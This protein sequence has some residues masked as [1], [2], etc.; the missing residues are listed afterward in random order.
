[1]RAH[2]AIV[3]AVPLLLCGCLAFEPL[4]ETPPP[5]DSAP[6]ITGTYPPTHQVTLLPT[7]PSV[8]NCDIT[9]SVTALAPQGQPL[10]A[11]FYLN[12]PSSETVQAQQLPD[13]QSFAPIPLQQEPNSSTVYQLLELP[14]YPLNYPA[15]LVSTSTTQLVNLITVFVS[16]GFDPDDPPNAVDSNH[17]VTSWDWEMTVDPAC[18]SLFNS[19]V[20]Q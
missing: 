3:F 15:G 14:L 17:Y 18:E 13:A 12:Y 7:D 5:V 1:M 16:D 2:G 19:A 4:T 10:Y 11:L 8:K 6:S 20:I 9:V